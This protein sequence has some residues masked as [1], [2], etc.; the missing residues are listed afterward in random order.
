MWLLCSIPFSFSF[1][2]IPQ[3]EKQQTPVGRSS[4]TQTSG[5]AI[6]P[7]MDEEE[8]ELQKIHFS[9][10]FNPVALEEAFLSLRIII[11]VFIQDINDK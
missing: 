7:G 2:I 1:F 9:C 3:F 6:D 5:G 11:M 8:V 10:F 4:A